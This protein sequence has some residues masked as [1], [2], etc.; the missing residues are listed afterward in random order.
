MRHKRTLNG[1]SAI[2]PPLWTPFH[3]LRYGA[4]PDDPWL[5][6]HKSTYRALTLSPWCTTGVR[7]PP[8]VSVLPDDTLTSLGADEFGRLR[9]LM[10]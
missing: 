3:F 1:S 7:A 8:S 4:H 5:A 2:E 10:R 6:T 9:V